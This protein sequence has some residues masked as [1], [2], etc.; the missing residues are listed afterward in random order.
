[1]SLDKRR[2]QCALGTR[3]ALSILCKKD[4]EGHAAQVATPFVPPSY[5]VIARRR[6][7]DSTSLD[8][9]ASLRQTL[10]QRHN[11]K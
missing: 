6:Y 5:D 9:I 1:M 7:I 2:L 3:G 4:T 8:V 11:I 10:C